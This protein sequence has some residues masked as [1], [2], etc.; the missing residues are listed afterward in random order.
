MAE[1][2]ILYRYVAMDPAGKRVTG[3]VQARSD[4][5]AFERL[6]RDGFSPVSIT[7]AK[8][9]RGKSGGGER[10]VGGAPS[11]RETGELL[12][13][14]AALLEAGADMRS[15]LSILGA[16]SA[17]PVVARACKALSVEIS[18]GG[19]LD[20][21]FA[22][23]LA[24][25]HVF[26]SALVAAGEA[27]GDLGGGLKRASE[28]LEAQLKLRDQLVSVLSYPAFVF[29][30][31]VAAVGVILIFVVPSLAPLAESGGAPPPVALRILIGASAVLRGNGLLLVVLAGAGL[32]GGVASAR[33]GLL[34]GPVERI[35]LDGPGRRTMRG[36]TYGAFSIALG[37]MLSAGA[38]MGEALRLSVRAVRAERARRLLEPVTQ[39][40][41]QGVL[42]STAL[43]RVGGF[44][45][46]I[47][48]LAA[49]GEATGALG[50]MLVRAGRLEEETAL[51]RIEQA[52]RLLG[53]VLIVC[54]GGLVG[55]L[56]AGLLTGVSQLGDTALQ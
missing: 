16:R 38:P 4:G 17:R 43:E 31:T 49:V 53:P 18:G 27:S 44:P 11:D 45:A 46:A 20:R 21:A 22:R 6:K 42:L 28:M 23:H 29:L 34:T 15:A 3:E 24:P 52:G 2:D 26:V 13:D 39:A 50:P 33:L 10:S 37:T 7:P 35:L 9:P 14:L 55:L 56:M 5:S 47:V 48:R 41:R 1:G 32:V 12:A 54:L 30:S 8:A 40:V 19:A 51:R 36:V 25:R